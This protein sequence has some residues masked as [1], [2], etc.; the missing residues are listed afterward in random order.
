MKSFVLVALAG[1]ALLVLPVAAVAKGP[2]APAAV[3]ASGKEKI[4]ADGAKR[5]DKGQKRITE[6]ADDTRK[7]EAKKRKGQDRVSEGNAKITT[8]QESYKRYLAGLTAASDPKGA[9]AQ[10][11]GLHDAAKRWEDA[12][13]QVHDG[14]KDIRKADDDIAGA[15][16]K[17]A[18]GEAMLAEGKSLKAQAGDVLVPVTP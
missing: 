15:A 1:A 9:F 4:W 17:K 7:A 6:A 10:A 8:A 13:N 16:R 11:D 5:A 18:E 14:E 12:V 2:A 3:I